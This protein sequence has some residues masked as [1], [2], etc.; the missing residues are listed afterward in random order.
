[1]PAQQDLLQPIGSS[2][3]A[4]RDTAE[5]GVEVAGLRELE[6]RSLEDC[7]GLLQ[8]GDRNRCAMLHSLRWRRLVLDPQCAAVHL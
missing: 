5:G 3:L 8:L 7:L 4:L 2:D 6:V 1:M